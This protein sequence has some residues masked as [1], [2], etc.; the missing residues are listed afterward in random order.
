MNTPCTSFPALIAIPTFAAVVAMTVA[1]AAG[2]ELTSWTGAR[3]SGSGNCTFCHDSGGGALVDGSGASVSITEDWRGTMMSHAFQDPLWQAVVEAET[4]ERPDL[5]EVIQGTCQTCHAPM[6]RHER[7]VEGKPVQDLVQARTDPL[8][9]DGVSC[10]V[11]HQIQ[12]GNLGRPESFSGGYEID[13]SRRI[14]GP[15][16]EPFS[17]PMQRHVDYTPVFS[18]HV[19]ESGLCAT[20]HTLH[21][22]MPGAEGRFPEQTPYLEWQASGYAQAGKHCQDCHMQRVEEPIRVSIRPPWLDPRRPFWRHQFVGGNAFMLGLFRDAHRTLE[23]NGTPQTLEAGMRR[24]REQL[25]HAARVEVSG[26]REGTALTLGVRVVNLAGHKFPTGHPYRR[27]WLHVRVTDARGRKVFE[28]G[29][30]DADGDLAGVGTGFLPHQ[31]ILTRPEQVQIYESVMGNAEGQ[32]TYGLLSAR[33]YLKDNRI[34]PRGSPARPEG[35]IAIRGEAV[36]DANFHA[37]GN[38]EDQVTY[39]VDTGRA[40][41]PFQVAVGLRYQSV[42][43][44]SVAWLRSVRGTA[45]KGFT[46]LYRRAD[47]TPETVSET[48]V[49]VE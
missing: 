32:R 40:R 45:S 47:K 19:G 1:T 35:D 43:P 49:T 42:P 24:A 38:G 2:A 3:F 7:R 39:R 30:V 18:A 23:P 17:M 22:P 13:A 14:F 37:G 36:Q 44:E 6:S 8:A 46:R 29:A 28:S 12:P 27:A 11:C 34:P 26:T 48:A 25:A 15:Y 33:T 4:L 5:R 9:W 41:G 21:T 31:D 20:C 10:T 16:E